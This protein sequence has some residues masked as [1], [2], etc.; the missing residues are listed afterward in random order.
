MSAARFFFISQIQIRKQAAT[1]VGHDAAG[2]TVCLCVC[3]AVCRLSVQIKER[4][5]ESE[6]EGE[7][8]IRAAFSS[9]VA[10]PSRFGLA[11][12]YPMGS[13]CAAGAVSQVAM[14]TSDSPSAAPSPAP[15][16][17]V[18]R[19]TR[20]QYLSNCH[21]LWHLRLINTSNGARCRCWVLCA[22]LATSRELLHVARC[23]PHA[24]AC[25]QLSLLLPGAAY[26][27]LWRVDMAR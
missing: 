15:A 26:R 2:C 4:E 25:R 1:K 27:P 5:R 9:Q 19:A 20:R 18:R 17:A 16:L 13:S 11:T 23:T 7:R 24:A 22:M 6:S 8:D 14:V 12:N 21:S 3:T 10:G